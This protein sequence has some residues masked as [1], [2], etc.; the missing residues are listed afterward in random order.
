MAKQRWRTDDR[1]RRSP[2]LLRLELC[3]GAIFTVGCLTLPICFPSRAATAD[4]P[5]WGPATDPAVH[6]LELT[7]RCRK[8]LRE[9]RVLGDLN[10]GLSVHD[11]VVSLWGSVPTVDAALRVEERLR[12]VLGIAGISNSLHIGS[13]TM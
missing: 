7:L 11:Q 10:I 9:D 5:S 8:A 3:A 1:S 6:D 2:V 13:G 4:T 12:Q